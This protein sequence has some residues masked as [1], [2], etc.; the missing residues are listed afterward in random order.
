V[1]APRRRGLAAVRRR[2]LVP[3]TGDGAGLGVDEPWALDVHYGRWACPVFGWVWVP[4]DVWGPAW[5]DWFSATGFVGWAPLSRLEGSSSATSSSS[6]KQLLRPH[7]KHAVSWA[8][9]GR[10]EPVID[11]RARATAGPNLG[12]PSGP[13][14]TPSGAARRVAATRPWRPGTGRGESLQPRSAASA[15]RKSRPPVATAPLALESP[16]ARAWTRAAAQVRARLVW[17]SRYRP[18]ISS[19]GRRSPSR[20]STPVP[21]CRAWPRDARRR[22]R[23]SHMLVGHLGL[24][25]GSS[26]P[27]QDSRA[28]VRGPSGTPRA[29]RHAATVNRSLACARSG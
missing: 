24:A 4:G 28:R 19:R 14:D 3:W 21:A 17:G 12:A 11:D 22:Q 6:T 7:L 25:R 26:L 23:P 1:A 15:S 13:G 9:I 20:P 27:A 18:A 10:A 16:A 8:G 29:S 5:V 2:L